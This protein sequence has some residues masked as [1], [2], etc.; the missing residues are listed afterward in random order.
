MC[1][2]AARY[3]PQVAAGTA[4][5]FRVLA[6]ESRR[7]Q[8]A[9]LMLERWEPRNHWRVRDLRGPHNAAPSKETRKLI[10]V[11]VLC[12]QAVAGLRP[13]AAPGIASNE[14]VQLPPSAAHDL[15]KEVCA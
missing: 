3:A 13:P 9:T 1:H 7:T 2:C 14:E 5:F 10:R 11:Y 6:S 8:R 12:A 15:C 4:F